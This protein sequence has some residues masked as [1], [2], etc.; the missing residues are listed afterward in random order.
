M[1]PYL[2]SDFDHR[3]TWQTT[4]LPAEQTMQLVKSCRQQ[5]P[6]LP[7]HR[8]QVALSLFALR[9]GLCELV[10]NA[11]NAQQVLHDEKQIDLVLK[12]KVTQPL[13]WA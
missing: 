8:L 9:C 6:P 12:P 1:P 2:P 13:L 4:T 11:N 10:I 5:P 3:N 7:G